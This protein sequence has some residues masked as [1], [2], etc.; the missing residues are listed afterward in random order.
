[1][2][3]FLRKTI[4]SLS[5]CIW[6]AGFLTA[7]L[8]SPSQFL[9]HTIGEQFTPHHMLVDYFEYVAANSDLVELVPYGKTNQDRP[10]M[11]AIVSSKANMDRLEEIRLNNLRLAGMSDGDAKMDQPVAIV[12][13]SYSVHGNEPSG[14]ESSMEVLYELVNPA[15]QETKTWLENTVVIIDPSVNP[16]GYDR[17]TH[18]F[19]NAGN[20]IPNPLLNS[21]EHLEPWPGGRVN[22]YQFDLNRDWAW[23]TQVE[24]QQR[25]KLYQEWLPHV[26]PDLHE[27]YI[28]N[29][30]YFAPAAEPFH[31]YITQWQ[32]DF[33]SEIGQ[34]NAQY[35]D[36]NGWLYFTKEVFDLFYPSYG[37]T[38]PT[39]NGAIGMTYEQAGHSAGGRQAM[40]NNGDTLTL[41][42]RVAHHK[43]TSLS[44]IEVS[45]K[46]AARLIQNFKKYF[47]QSGNNPVGVYK[48]FI[49]KNNPEDAGKIKALIRLLDQHKIKY[50]TAARSTAKI[51]AYD[52]TGGKNASIEI[53]S[54]DLIISAFQPKSV[55]AQVLLEPEPAL[56]DSLTY[57]I[58]SWSLP[59]AYGLNAYA[60]RQRID[61]KPG[62]QTSVTAL[63]NIGSQNPYAVFAPW[64]SVDNAAF[65]SEILKKGIV[66]R[67]SVESFSSGNRNF[68]AGTLVVT[69]ADNRNNNDWSESVAAAAKKTGQ[70]IIAANTGWMQSGKD[71]G[72]D[73]MRLITAPAVALV[74]GEEVDNNAYGFVWNYLEQ[75]INYP[76]SAIGTGQMNESSLSG[77]NTVILPE[78]SYLKD[79]VVAELKKW[80][81]KGGK[82]IALGGAN[83]AFEGKE[84]FS[85]PK[86]EDES[87][88][89]SLALPKLYAASER[90]QI[91][92]GTPGAIVKIELDNSHPLAF[93]LG[94]AYFTLKTNNAHYPLLNEGWNVGKV[95]KQIQKSGFV[96]AKLLT[97]MS[98]T[99]SF[100]VQNIG[101]G[102]IIYLTD[103]P[104]FRGFWYQG[105]LLFSNALFLN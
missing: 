42:D 80:A 38:Y 28:D 60:T 35:F 3:R 7:Q 33:Q 4:A 98:D 92:E 52:Y 2:I 63:P 79:E 89:D 85:L 14:S 46:N 22:H 16:D 19:R 25:I 20:R 69:H 91:T 1:M 32:R 84:G 105:K 9:P 74:Y 86:V 12:W 31:Q 45:S 61:V 101:A 102:K 93:G 97:K 49:I 10:L 96:G 51:E 100:G 47:D 24:S 43:T 94:S 82:I 44:T 62:F 104:L 83:K 5:L 66:V 103:D 65:L 30:Y 76:F 73:K 48:T 99:M 37:D 90:D 18:W 29:P 78:G 13:L 72:S 36:K 21:R 57:D 95:G 88:S 71:L 67:S 68:R 59:Y 56:S 34:N 15:N 53:S 27:Q 6:F 11:V 58:T 41:E 40:M 54:N 70:E 23:L 50:G 39:F 64:H 26:H 87:K 8:L 81:T 77:F 17:Y 55:L 75:N